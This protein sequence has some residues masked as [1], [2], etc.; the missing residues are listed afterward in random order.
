MSEFFISR[1][2]F[3]WVLAIV[4]M[5]AGSLAIL[6]LPI[7]QY[8]AI[9][10]PAIGV[11]VSYPGA[12][13]DTVQSTVVQVIEQQLSGIDNLLYFNSESDK[14]GSMTIT[15]YFQQGTNADIA[16]VRKRA[17]KAGVSLDVE[18]EVAAD[19]GIFIRAGLNDGRKEA[20]EFTEINRTVAAGVSIGGGRWKRADDM[21]GFAA[22]VNGLSRQA[23]D[24]FAAGG[25]GL[26]IGDGR[27][28]YGN[29]Q[30]IETYYAARLT[31]F[32]RLTVDYQHVDHPAYNRDRGPVSI[33]SVRLHLEH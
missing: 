20:Y 27:L 10:P 18:Q 4:V 13:A 32:A 23:R 2:I 25:L 31:S 26:L 30:I 5:L 14:D 1:P 28:N 21:F 29:E 6:P 16:M 7:S 8:P 9:A 19:A 33:Y 11:S 12:S 15:L 24:F 17:S 3:A 22:V